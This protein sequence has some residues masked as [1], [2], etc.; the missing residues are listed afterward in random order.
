[1]STYDQTLGEYS[2]TGMS[3]S[4]LISLTRES[5]LFMAVNAEFNEAPDFA[6]P[7]RPSAWWLGLTKRILNGNPRQRGN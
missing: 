3:D 5:W 2:S 1:M 4:I 6:F 7:E